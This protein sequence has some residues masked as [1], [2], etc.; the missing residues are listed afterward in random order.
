[1][2]RDKNVFLICNL[3]KSNRTYPDTNCTYPDK[4]CGLTKLTKLDDNKGGSIYFCLHS[5]LEMIRKNPEFLAII[6]KEGKIDKRME[7][8]IKTAEMMIKNG[9]P[10][11]SCP[12]CGNKMSGYLVMKLKR[13]AHCVFCNQFY[14]VYRA[15]KC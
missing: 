9:M 4:E 6:T 5:F 12:Y 11:I 7:R 15:K 13:I 3:K 2:R 8:D 14:R 10:E 1:M